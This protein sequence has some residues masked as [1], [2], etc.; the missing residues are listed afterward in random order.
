MVDPGTGTVPELAGE[1]ARA[2]REIKCVSAGSWRGSHRFEN[3]HS[4]EGQ[5]PDCFGIL[6]PLK[7]GVS[8]RAPGAELSIE[9][10]TLY[11]RQSHI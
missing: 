9:G 1:D 11:L 3:Y 10:R 8:N 7:F 2:T 4:G 6:Q 5:R